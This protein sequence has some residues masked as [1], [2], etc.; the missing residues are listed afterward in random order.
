MQLM[1][2]LTVTGNTSAMPYEKNE[3]SLY[4][5]N[6]QCFIYKGRAVVTDG[7]K[8]YDVVVYDGI[9]DF[10]K[11]IE[12]KAL[13]FVG[14]EGLNHIKTLDNII[15]TWQPASQSPYR[16]IIADYNGNNGLN[17]ANGNLILADYLVPSANVAYIWKKIF[18]KF[19]FTYSGAI[20]NT[21]AFKDLWLTYPKGKTLQDE[22]TVVFES[23]N[24]RFRRSPI[25]HGQSFYGMFSTAQQQYYD[26]EKTHIHVQ[27]SGQYKIS[28]NG[29]IALLAYP[30][31][32]LPDGFRLYIAKNATGKLA[33]QTQAFKEVL[34]YPRN[35]DFTTYVFVNLNAGDSVSFVVT[36]TVGSTVPFY[37]NPS[38]SWMKVKIEKVNA[39]MDF[40]Q[41]FADFSIRDFCTE[42]M[43]RFGLTM[44]KEKY[45]KPDESSGTYKPHYNFLTLAEQLQG[46]DVIDWSEKYCNKEKEAYVHNSY[47]RQNWFRYTYNDK[48]SS[49]YDDYLSIESINLPEQK[50]VVKSRIYAPEKITRKLLGNRVNVYKL[51]EKEVKE[52]AD[53][54]EEDTIT[55]K[56]LDKRYYL[57]RSKRVVKNIRVLLVD[58]LEYQTSNHGVF[59][60]YS[61]MPF[62]DVLQEYYAPLGRLLDKSLIVTASMYLTEHDICNF[63]FKKLFYIRQLSNYF[64][65]NKISN[66][67]PGKPVKCEMVKVNYTDAVT[68]KPKLR[69]TKV[70][71]LKHTI[72][73]YFDNNTGIVHNNGYL[74]AVNATNGV[75]YNTWTL[76][77][78]PMYADFSPSGTFKIRAKIGDYASNE[79]TINIP[80]NTTITPPL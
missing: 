44:Y 13:P 39:E 71:T 69:I 54:E 38:D 74:I 55:Y 77:N 51:W 72:T 5:D 29:G 58:T 12:S 36:N 52:S 2:F 76:N 75:Q 27:E 68:E 49:Y 50:D 7:G 34:N 31:S 4:S 59:E 79:V 78:N 11:E 46:A 32:P 48:E 65:V 15:S 62:Y 66:Y 64:I 18:D 53:E 57:M 28:L 20:F 9:I 43:Q 40:E 33:N 42:I 63:D 21:Q 19:G 6:G 3:C 73:V 35:T 56:S 60:S 22:S 1:D 10:Y 80:S 41:A 26:S 61:K 16:Y 24:F 70:T 45:D 47:A 67:V 30:H 23:E 8:Y 37:V 17:S 14:L 25:T